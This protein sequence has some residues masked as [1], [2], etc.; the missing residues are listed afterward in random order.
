MA[1]LVVFGEDWGALPSSTQHLIRHLLPKHRVI[2]VNSIGLRS[3]QLN[4]RDAKRLLQKAWAIISGTRKT[5]TSQITD[6]TPHIIHPIA[7]PFYRNQ[8]VR[9]INRWLLSALIKKGMTQHRMSNVILWISLPTAVD[10]VGSLQEQS[11]IY[12]CGDDFGALDNVD[13]QLA[14]TLEAELIPKANLI[15]T[16]SEKLA[17]KFPTH[18]TVTLPHGVD[19]ELF[20]SP[21]TPA[22]DIPQQALV[23]GFYG[24]ISSWLD[25]DLLVATAKALP[26]WQFVF[27]GRSKVDLTALKELPNTHFLGFKPHHELPSYVQHWDVA[28]L[29]FRQNNQIEACN[30]LKLTEYLA[31]GTAIAATRFPAVEPFDPFVA[32]QKDN[33]PFAETLLRAHS[34]KPQGALRQKLVINNTWQARSQE[35]ETLMEQQLHLNQ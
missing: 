15:I 2:W 35:L 27:I 24:S 3:P 34:L 19:Y 8:F 28:L 4:I 25:I 12:Y 10:M 18:K 17:G 26:Q 7:L 1:D 6:N 29:P 16:A 30:P 33:E 13:H 5:T 23:T 21:H 22:A 20:A 11:V 31:S 32:I 14:E 9:R